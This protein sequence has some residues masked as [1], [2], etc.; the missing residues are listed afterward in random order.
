MKSI[1]LILLINFSSYNHDIDTIRS[2]Y[3]SAYISEKNC[4]NFREKIKNI[5]NK[6]S[7]LMQAYEGCFYFIKCQFINNPLEKFKYFKKGKE[8]L[9][10]AIKEDPKSV[11][12]KLLRY[13]IQKNLPR[14]LLY[15]DN[16]EKDLNFV[17]ENINSIN[18]KKVQ[19]FI[20]TT[21]KSMSK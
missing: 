20:T 16:I 1:L 15:Y 21:L 9:E 8:L 18:D 5:E 10:T 17:T 12:L 6:N 2:L 11:E 4:N 3:L 7:I 13:S 19:K 14:F